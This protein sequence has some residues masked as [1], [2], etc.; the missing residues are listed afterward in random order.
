LQQNVILCSKHLNQVTSFV[1]SQKYVTL[2][3]NIMY[4]KCSCYIDCG[5]IWLNTLDATDLHLMPIVY[6]FPI[7]VA[8]SV[9]GASE[10]DVVVF[11]SNLRTCNCATD[12][13]S[14]FIHVLFLE[15]LSV[16]P[17]LTHLT[18]IP[19]APDGCICQTQPRNT[20]YMKFP[21]ETHASKFP[22]LPS[23]SS[24]PQCPTLQVLH[25]SNFCTVT[26]LS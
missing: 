23:M 24:L 7:L 18:L 11:Y 15:M 13:K 19:Y 12:F 1:F 26:Y 10:F 25:P 2:S 16:L 17:A 20:K 5:F 22:P 8:L 3:S 14:T 21:C 4:L 9:F 6:L